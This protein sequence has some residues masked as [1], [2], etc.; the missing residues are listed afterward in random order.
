M[1]QV[2]MRPL[3]VFASKRLAK[4]SLL[5]EILLTEENQLNSEEFM[6]LVKIWLKILK[7]ET[8]CGTSACEYDDG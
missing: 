7:H 8:L 3:K 1:K 4:A 5:R 2:D 6:A